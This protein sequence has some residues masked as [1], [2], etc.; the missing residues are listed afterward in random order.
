V[1]WLL[2]SEITSRRALQDSRLVSRLH[3]LLQQQPPQPLPLEVHHVNW[4]LRDQ[5]LKY[6]LDI[7][8]FSFGGAAPTAGLLQSSAPSAAPTPS[9]GL[10][11]FS[12]TPSS[13]P[14]PLSNYLPVSFTSYFIEASDKFINL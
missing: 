3:F 1:Q 5:L 4:N 13:Q 14:A 12:A 7:P 2:I 11:A 10:G 8:G 9:F 6:F